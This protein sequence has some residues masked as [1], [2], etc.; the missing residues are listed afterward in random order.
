MDHNGFVALTARMDGERV[1][2]G[3]I[4]AKVKVS[5][6][7][8]VVLTTF[9][10][11]GML[12]VFAGLDGK[13]GEDADAELDR[14]IE[15]V[16]AMFAGTGDGLAALTMSCAAMLGGERLGRYVVPAADPKEPA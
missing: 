9:A 4:G 8:L 15:G 6:M 13:Q 10:R 5:Q 14:Q 2:V 12:S 3:R 11:I 7:E 16:R 1:V